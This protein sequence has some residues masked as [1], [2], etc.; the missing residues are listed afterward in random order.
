VSLWQLTPRSKESL[1]VFG[2]DLIYYIQGENRRP[3]D[4]FSHGSYQEV[5]S[6]VNRKNIGLFVKE[7]SEKEEVL[8]DYLSKT[9]GNNRLP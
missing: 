9:A 8:L 6:S 3:T 7:T 4:I 2:P 5:L 1:A